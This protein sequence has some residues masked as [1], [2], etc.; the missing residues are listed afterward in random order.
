MSE[1]FPL[2]P[3]VTYLNVFVAHSLKW[4]QQSLKCRLHLR[5]SPDETETCISSLITNKLG[6]LKCKHQL[7]NQQLTDQSKSTRLLRF[8][9]LLPHT[10]K[11]NN[12]GHVEC[13]LSDYVAVA[14]CLTLFFRKTFQS[15]A[16]MFHYYFFSFWREGG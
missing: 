4:N 5:G 7:F 1:Y 15:F 2:F 6:K 8:L 10:T 14:Q 11:N 12:S 13:T 3:P 16:E 9:V